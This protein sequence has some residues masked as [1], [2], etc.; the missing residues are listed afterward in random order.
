MLKVI[1]FAI[2]AFLSCGSSGLAEIGEGGATM[3]I[4]GVPGLG[5]TCTAGQ[6]GHCSP[7][8]LS[9]DKGT[10]SYYPYALY[11][12]RS[13]NCGGSDVGTWP[14]GIQMACPVLG[15]SSTTIIPSVPDVAGCQGVLRYALAVSRN[16]GG[17]TS[18]DSNYNPIAEVSISLTHP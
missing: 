17:C 18:I 2:A 12:L 5:S 9:W 11:R 15:T 13:Y 4:D 1:A 16:G 3:A 10:T 7:K 8:T 6:D 14:P